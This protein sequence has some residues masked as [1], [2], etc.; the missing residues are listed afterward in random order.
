MRSCYSTFWSP[1]KPVDTVVN[2]VPRES[3]LLRGVNKFHFLPEDDDFDIV[4]LVRALLKPRCPSAIPGFVVSVIFSAI[5]GVFHGGSRA[6]VGIEVFK[7]V[8]PSLAH[9]YSPASIVCKLVVVGVL[10]SLF[11]FHPN[12][13][14]TRFGHAVF[15]QVAR[16]ACASVFPLEASTGAGAVFFPNE[17]G[18]GDTRCAPAVTTAFPNSTTAASCPFWQELNHYKPAESLSGKV[19]APPAESARL[20][21]TAEK[22]ARGDKGASP[23]R[24]LA[25]PVCGL[26]YA[27]TSEGDRGKFTKWVPGQVLESLSF[28]D[29]DNFYASSSAVLAHVIDGLSSSGHGALQRVVAALYYTQTDAKRKEVS[30]W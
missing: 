23:A 22:V 4:S 10:A 19:L 25:I 11:H 1:S 20:A 3:V 9:L 2:R 15:F 16:C 28:I 26:L 8:N 21:Q 30:P 24:T 12:I 27:S 6:H 14:F 17:G 18:C 13:E 5:D 7:R 29:G